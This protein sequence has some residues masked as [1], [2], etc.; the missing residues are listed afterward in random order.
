MANSTQ[1]KMSGFITICTKELRRFFTDKRMVLTTILLPGLMIYLIYSFMGTAMGDMFAVDEDYQPTVYAVNLPAELKPYFTQADIE[2]TAIEDAQSQIDDVKSQITD[3]EADALIV[4]P[5]DFETSMSNRSY[6]GDATS[7][8]TP[9]VSIYYNSTRTES[10]A[11]YGAVSAVLDAYKSYLQPTAFTTN[12]SGDTDLATAQDSTGQLF[13]MLLPF[14]VIIMLFSGSMGQSMESISGEKERGTFATL[15]VTPLKRWELACGKIVS[16]SIIALLSGASSF[17][18]IVLALPNIVGSD[19]MG[20][21]ASEQNVEQAG[22]LAV[23]LYTPVDFLL[24]FV[25]ILATVLLFV[26]LVS[27][28]S[29]FARSVKEATTFSMPLM[30]AVMVVG[31]TGMFTQGAQSDFWFYL[32]PVYN[33][34]QAMVGIF[35]FAYDPLF[36]ALTVVSNLAYTGICVVILTW[37]FSNER[38]M[39]AR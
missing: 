27:L 31:I 37:M 16:I 28:L 13:S 11:V 26:G 2:T 22:T 25:V 33:S 5:G 38:I 34:V 14:I 12:A 21:V 8:S 17:L 29:A 32:I 3:K 36:V 19:T 18:G 35:S 23:S 20:M 30:I 39:F 6:A 4:F 24:L 10:T 9:D 7:A 1:A 15:L